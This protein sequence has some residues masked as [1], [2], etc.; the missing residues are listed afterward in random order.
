MNTETIKLAGLVNE[1][2]G[3]LDKMDE[4]V[5]TGIMDQEALTNYSNHKRKY[6]EIKPLVK[7]SVNRMLLSQGIYNSKRVGVQAP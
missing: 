7:Y 1:M 6:R 4:I 2:V 3:H 5:G